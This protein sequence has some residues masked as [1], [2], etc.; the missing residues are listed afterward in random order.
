[1]CSGLLSDAWMQR[2]TDLVL[3]LFLVFRPKTKT[4]PAAITM[5]SIIISY[6]DSDLKKKN[7][8]VH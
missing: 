1:M 5:S 7:V 3:Y 2:A 4:A 8:F 6:P